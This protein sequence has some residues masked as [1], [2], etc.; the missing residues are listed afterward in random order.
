[1]SAIKKEE[2]V[3]ITKTPHGI[4]TGKEGYIQEKTRKF[5]EVD[6]DGDFIWDGLTLLEKDLPG[7]PLPQR[8]YEDYV[9]VDYPEVDYGNFVKKAQTVTYVYSGYLYIIFLPEVGG[10]IS[11]N[12][13]QFKRL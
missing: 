3:I 11:V 8:I 6:M 10:C 5:T 1:M 7:G 9:E 2:K 4:Y 13:D 12:E